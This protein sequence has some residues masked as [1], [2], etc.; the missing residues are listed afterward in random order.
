MLF[1]GVDCCCFCLLSLVGVHRLFVVC[2][3]S[4]SIVVLLLSLVGVRRS[5]VAV[6]VVR[7]GAVACVLFV[8]VRYLQFVVV[9]C[10]L[11]LFVCCV[12]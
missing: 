12:C 4:V 5:C 7:I 9:V 11:L 2:C 3:M 1:L 8:V 6:V 10:L